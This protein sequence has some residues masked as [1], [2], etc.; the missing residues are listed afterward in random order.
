MSHLL[1]A[2]SVNVPPIVAE[3]AKYHRW[4]DPG[5]KRAIEDPAVGP[6]SRRHARLAMLPVDPGQVPA[7]LEAM[8]QA[9]PDEFVIERDALYPRRAE[10]IHPAS[11]QVAESPPKARPTRPSGRPSRWRDSYDPSE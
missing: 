1:D 9:E 6:V 5:L 3:L 7:L 2:D 10:L 8:L 11:G 4:A